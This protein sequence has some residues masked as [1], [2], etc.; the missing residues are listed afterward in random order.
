LNSFGY[1][2]LRVIERDADPT[3]SRAG[4]QANQSW[5]GFLFDENEA[6][7][8]RISKSQCARNFVAKSEDLLLISHSHPAL[9]G[10]PRATASNFLTVL[11]V[12]IAPKETV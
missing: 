1:R 7:D 6:K 12:S 10:W 8:K 4:R 3:R 11:T 9:A 2:E 5:S